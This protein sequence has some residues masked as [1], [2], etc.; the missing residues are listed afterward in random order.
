MQ[1]YWIQNMCKNQGT[2]F[3]GV[4]LVFLV[5]SRIFNPIKNFGKIVSMDNSPVTL[6]GVNDRFFPF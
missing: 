6:L 2:K 5:D 4:L 3:E 1:S